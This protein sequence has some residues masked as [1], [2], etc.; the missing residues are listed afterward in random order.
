ME[1]PFNTTIGAA[2]III[3]T[4]AL[5]TWYQ[6]TR[7]QQLPLPPGPPRLP[8]LGNTNFP[9]T[10]WYDKFWELLEKH[11]PRWI[12]IFCELLILMFELGDVVYL[13]VLGQSTIILGS[14]EV[15]EELLSKRAS[16]YSRRSE[17]FFRMDMWVVL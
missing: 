2:T 13:E 11:G 9:Q 4:S 16:N 6:H 7:R 17:S 14:V 1:N 10:Q 15:A 3:A 8:L 5:Y 12:S